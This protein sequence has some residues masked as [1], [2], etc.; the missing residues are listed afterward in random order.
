MISFPLNFSGTLSCPWYTHSYIRALKSG[1]VVI[2]GVLGL[3][4]W[5]VVLENETRLLGLLLKI[6]KGQ[7]FQPN[8]VT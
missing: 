5:D 4:G 7:R 2:L 3:A 1:V 6:V 8:G